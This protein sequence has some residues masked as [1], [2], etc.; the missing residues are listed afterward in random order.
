MLDGLGNLGVGKYKITPKSVVNSAESGIIGTNSRA[1]V[2]DVHKIGNIDIE[3]FKAITDKKILTNQV[4]ITDNRIKHI[5]ERRGQDFYNEYGKY[6]SD[7]LANPD[8]IF[9]DDKENTALVSKS[10]VHK[11]STVNLVLRLVVEGE[12]PEYKNSI[13]TAIKESNKRFAQRLR[14][15][16][17]V[18]RVDTNE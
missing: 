13:I 2:E 3:K 4:I 1:V 6:F 15:N 9:K 16:E 10:F 12:N 18:Y 5:I 7:I 14:N 11:G 17:P 8:Y